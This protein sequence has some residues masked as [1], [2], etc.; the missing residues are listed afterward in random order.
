MGLSKQGDPLYIPWGGG[1]HGSTLNGIWAINLTTLEWYIERMPSDP[2]AKGL[3]W[4][5]EYWNAPHWT[6]YRPFEATPAK[7]MLPDGEPTSRH[8]YQGVWYDSRRDKIGQG[9]MSFWKRLRTLL[10]D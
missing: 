1:H 9:L 7:D 5:E 3:E 10:R 6:P 4:S 2:Y 8:T